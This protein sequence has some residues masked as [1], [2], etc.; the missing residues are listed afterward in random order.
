MTGRKMFRRDRSGAASIEFALTI[1]VV[2][3]AVLGIFEVGFIFLTQRGIERGVTETARWVA[4]NSATA[5]ASA[6]LPIFTA[7]STLALGSASASTC[8]MTTNAVTAS[9]SGC[10]IN[11]VCGSGSCAVGNTVTVTAQFTWLPFTT[12]VPI[13]S[14]TMIASAQLTILD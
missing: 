4:V 5:T 12:L 7:A 6:A 13:A 8:T 14:Y 1:M 10:V 3:I 2:L 9:T 11:L